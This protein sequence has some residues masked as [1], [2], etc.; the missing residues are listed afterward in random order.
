MVSPLPLPMRAR[1]IGEDSEI[2]PCVASLSTSPCDLAGTG[3]GKVFKGNTQAPGLT[4]QINGSVNFLSD[5]VILQPSTTYYFN[6]VNRN[7]DGSKSCATS[8]CN[9]IIQLTLPTGL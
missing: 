4:Y 7:A 5:R 6:I 3:T 2:L 1:A 9:M 8:T